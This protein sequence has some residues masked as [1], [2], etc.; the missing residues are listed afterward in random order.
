MRLVMIGDIGVRDEMIHIGDEAMFETFARELGRRGFDITALS[1]APEESAARYG[2]DAVARIGFDLSLGR[3]AARTRL[4][5]VLDGSLPADDPAH[6]VVA[7][8]ESSD[9]VAIA[10]GG[11]MASTWPTHIYERAALAALAVRSGVPLVVSGQTLGPWLEDEDRELLRGLLG[12]AALVGVREG[13]SLALAGGLGQTERTRRTVDDASFLVDSPVAREEYALV[14][15]STHLGAVPHEE[16]VSSIA[17]SLDRV[18]LTT[19]LPVL[20]HAHWASLD[21]D[22]VRGDTV[23]HEEVRAAMTSP[24]GVVPTRS[25]THSARIARAASMVVTSRY[26]PAVFAAPAGVPILGIPVDD[27]TT[28]KLTGALD[29][30]GQEGVAPLTSLDD[31]PVADLWGQREA[32]RARAAAISVAERARTAAWWDRIAGIYAG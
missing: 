19:G 10:G 17:R 3:D 5:Q 26:H 20:F 12:A 1:S 7:A 2:V 28:I 18:A 24:S 27:Y 4:G 30:F 8:V 31:A 32:I 23:L 14:S 11:N 25:S 13:A 16:G 6:A 15:L 22:Q 21:P 9:G 29:N